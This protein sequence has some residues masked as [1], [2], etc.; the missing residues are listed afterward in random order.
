VK[1]LSQSK[2]YL[3][4]VKDIRQMITNDGLKQGDKIPS[5]RELTERLKVGRSSVREA[6]R[7]LELLGL[8]ETR[9]GEGTFLGDFKNNQL[10]KLLGMFILED[11]N[12]KNDIT[13]T[14]KL[15]EKDIIRNICL[16]TDKEQLQALR[17]N[18]NEDSDILFDRIMDLES[19]RLLY[20]IWDVLKS[21]SAEIMDDHAQLDHNSVISFLD[22]LIEGNSEKAIAIYE[23][24]DSSRNLI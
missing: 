4:I 17:K 23:R 7:S 19:N 22:A 1:K 21:Y 9:R 8:I 6:L 5:E 12:V 10:I 3:S 24:K 20:R 2:V 16:L 18:E 15:L 13:K 11:P 14:K